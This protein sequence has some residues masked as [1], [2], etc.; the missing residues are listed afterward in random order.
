MRI[1]NRPNKNNDEDRIGQRRKDIK[2]ISAVFP[3]VV[4]ELKFH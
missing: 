2:D 4:S 3:E 1:A